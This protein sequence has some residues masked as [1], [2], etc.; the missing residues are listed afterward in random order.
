MT[1][2]LHLNEGLVHGG[3]ENEI[4]LARTEI[5]TQ[6]KYN[7]HL[8]FGVAFAQVKIVEG[9]PVDDI[10]EGMSEG[11]STIVNEIEQECKKIGILR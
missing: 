8:S 1:R 2:P 5:G 10:L 7:I 9:Y 4:V 3:S 6:Y 11:V